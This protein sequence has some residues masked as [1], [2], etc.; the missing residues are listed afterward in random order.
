MSEC[1]SDRVVDVREGR[2]PLPVE[3]GD[4]HMEKLYNQNCKGECWTSSVSFEQKADDKTVMVEKT[5]S[6]YVCP[7]IHV[8]KSMSYD[9]AR[10]YYSML[11]SKGWLTIS[12]EAA[13]DI[14]L[15]IK[16]RNGE[17]N[18]RRCEG[19]K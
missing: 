5:I 13:K 10:K 16:W 11:R 14:E 15:D 2:T 1:K 6:S 19:N 4:G 12:E 17:I 7:S 8:A 18:G 3:R 9:Q